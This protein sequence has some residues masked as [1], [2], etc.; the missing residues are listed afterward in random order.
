MSLQ[1]LFMQINNELYPENNPFNMTEESNLNMFDK[2]LGTSKIRELFTKEMK[3]N[4]IKDYLEKDV[5]TFKEIS[6]KYYIY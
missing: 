2:V 6:K 3:Y 4:D 5:E 1:F